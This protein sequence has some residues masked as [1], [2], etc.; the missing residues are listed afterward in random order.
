M[1]LLPTMLDPMSHVEFFLV[2]YFEEL[3]IDMISRFSTSLYN[4]T[5]KRGRRFEWFLYDG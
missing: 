4:D 2:S 5:R 1:K 3:V